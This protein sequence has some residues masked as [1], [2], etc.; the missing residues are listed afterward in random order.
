MAWCDRINV[1]PADQ[2]GGKTWHY[3]LLGEATF[4]SWRDKGGSVGD[5]L[6]YAKLRPAEDHGQ[7]KFAF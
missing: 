6:A 4:Y 3:V 2:R 5:L 1:L 7:A